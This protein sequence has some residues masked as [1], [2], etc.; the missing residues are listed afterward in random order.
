ML[1][2]IK[3]IRKKGF[4]RVAKKG[5]ARSFILAGN[6]ATL[7]VTPSHLTVTPSHLTVSLRLG[8]AEISVLSPSEALTLADTLRQAVATL[9]V[10]HG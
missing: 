6:A 1:C 2:H 5:N 4:L 7:T 8:G 10:P 9:E 3:A